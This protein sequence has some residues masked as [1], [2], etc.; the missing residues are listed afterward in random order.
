MKRWK[1]K[2]HKNIS[3]L[4]QDVKPYIFHNGCKNI[5]N[6]IMG[7]NPL[8]TMGIMKEVDPHGI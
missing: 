4:L 8:P 5:S 2:Q 1:R 3:L 7:Y 6:N